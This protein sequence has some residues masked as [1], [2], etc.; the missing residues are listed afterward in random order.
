M[1]CRLEGGESITDAGLILPASVADQ[2]PVQ[3]GR[4]VAVGP[5][6]AMAPAGFSFDDDWEKQRAEPRWVAMQART[7]DLAVF[8]R[9]AAVEVT[10]DGQKLAI[11]SHGAILMLLRGGEGSPRIA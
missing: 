5:G 6:V 1:L 3:A 4:I 11:V 2:Q 10:V 9:K 8:F 7:G